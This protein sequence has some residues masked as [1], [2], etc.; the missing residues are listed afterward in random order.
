MFERIAAACVE[1]DERGTPC[2]SLFGD[3]YHSQHGGLGQAR[4]VF[5]GGNGLPARWRA[6]ERFTILE[7]GF[8]LGLNFL[9]SWQAWQQDPG[10]CRRLSYV[11]VE[12]HP[13]CAADLRE[14]HSAWP[15]LDRFSAELLD[16]W[17]PLVPG[18]HRLQ[19]ARGQVS[20]D[21]LFG[22]AD[23]GLSRLA[24][25]ADALYLDGFAP[26]RN[27]ALW[28]EK[29][30]HLLGRLCAPGAT[31]ATWSVAAGVRRALA[32]AGFETDKRPGFAGKREMLVGRLGPRLSAQSVER[33]LRPPA[34]RRAVVIGAGLAGC[35]LGE[36]LAA[37][38][39]QVELIEE[40]EAPAQGASGNLAGLLRP[41]PSLDDNPM[42]R[43]TRA[44]TLYAL[45]HLAGLGAAGHAVRWQAC[46]VLHLA[47]DAAHEARQRRVT[48]AH[49]PPPGYLQQL[50]R[51]AASALAG[52]PL[53]IGGWWFPGAAWVSPPTLCRA[54]LAQA[55]ARLRRA[56]GRRVA[57]LQRSA[58]QWRVIGPAGELLAESPV[59]VLA[60]GTGVGRLAQAAALPVRAA[61]GQVMHLPAQP[62]ASPTIALCG[63]GYLSPPIDGVRC[64]GATF[65]L[66]DPDETLRR[67]DQRAI[68]ERLER[69]LPGYVAAHATVELAGRVGFRPVTPDRLPMVGAIP[70]GA[71]PECAGRLAELARHDGLYVLG[72]FGARGLVW[73]ALLA[74][75]LAS[76]LEGEA[77]PL[78]SELAAALDPARFVLR[79]PRAGIGN[80]E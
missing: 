14:L 27:A 23:P 73:S 13:F 63:H 78:E 25:S 38:G 20:L 47:R 11:A 34:Q 28:S 10:R 44:G 71:A 64:V 17:P 18:L 80:Q 32:D 41:L 9:A 26:A 69:M 6:R 24:C 33:A 40:A 43:L 31:L 5:L 55:G 1:R 59:V 4:H 45:R 50:A 53:A 3:V 56:S 46:G 65:Q 67:E 35:A 70:T 79:P 37:R 66:D 76:R 8:G 61:R 2:S 75:L 16:A 68:L 22:D 42:S 21:L 57:A 60:N 62:A 36:R 77:P 19:L 51:D 39:W 58:D 15:E 72:G 52:W 29:L 49:D 30:F 12:K 48:E 7:T 54:N 74:E